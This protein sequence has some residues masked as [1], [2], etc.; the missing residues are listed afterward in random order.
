MKNTATSDMPAL[1]IGLGGVAAQA[2]FCIWLRPANC[3]AAFVLGH[4]SM[5][6]IGCK[7]GLGVRGGPGTRDFGGWGAFRGWGG[8]SR[9]PVP[10]AAEPELE[11]GPWP[12]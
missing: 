12:L 1:L 2:W 11:G 8:W 3:R 6:Q 9:L 10:W 7:S 4:C 5:R